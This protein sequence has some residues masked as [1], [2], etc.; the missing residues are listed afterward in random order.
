MRVIRLSLVSD[1]GWELH[2]NNNQDLKTIYDRL[3]SHPSLTNAGL[4]AYESLK[5]ENR[6]LSAAIDLRTEDNPSDI[7]IDTNIGQNTDKSDYRSTDGSLDK[8]F[9][10]IELESTR[11]S[12]IVWGL[13]PIWH[14]SR[15]IGLV[16]KCFYSHLR[17]QM[18][19]FGHIYRN[20]VLELP[21]DVEIQVFGKRYKARV[22]CVRART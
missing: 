4:R 6:Y 5:N 2:L 20:S 3:V 16:R 15:V 22:E 17:Q 18:M 1:I 8:F 11:E 14:N 9:V 19:A 7:G 21:S 10:W 13:E 12:P